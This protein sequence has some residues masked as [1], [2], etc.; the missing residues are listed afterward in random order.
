MQ[1]GRL[2]DRISVLEHENGELKAAQ[3][4]TK[5]REKLEEKLLKDLESNARLIDDLNL[6]SRLMHGTCIGELSLL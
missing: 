1:L 4:R 6:D 3:S 5:S 2:Q